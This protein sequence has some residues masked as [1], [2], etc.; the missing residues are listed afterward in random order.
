MN[1]KLL[2]DMWPITKNGRNISMDDWLV[3]DSVVSMTQKVLYQVMRFMA[4]KRFLFWYKKYQKFMPN[5]N[6]LYPTCSIW[7][8]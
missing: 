4:F 2:K 8:I 7:R 5:D 1:C 6:H 3:V